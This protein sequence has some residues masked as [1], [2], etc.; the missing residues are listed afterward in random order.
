MTVWLPNTTHCH[1]WK[2]ISSLF[3]LPSVYNQG[4]CIFS[5]RCDYVQ[6]WLYAIWKRSDF[7]SLRTVFVCQLALVCLSWS[8]FCKPRP[9]PSTLFHGFYSPFLL[10]P[11]FFAMHHTNWII[12]PAFPAQTVIFFYRQGIQV[13]NFDKNSWIEMPEVITARLHIFAR[14]TKWDCL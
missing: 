5:N 9:S 7:L 3:I 2:S 1:S 12:F 14:T 11:Y 6:N 13:F 10:H 4:F 8:K